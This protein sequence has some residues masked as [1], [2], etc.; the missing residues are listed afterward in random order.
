M[1]KPEEGL[2]VARVTE[3]GERRMHADENAV[4]DNQMRQLF[5]DRAKA[6]EDAQEDARKQRQE[7]AQRQAEA[8]AARDHA[9]KLAALQAQK[10]KRCHNCMIK[11]VAGLIIA[12]G[13][14]VATHCYGMYV[15]VAVVTGCCVAAVCRVAWYVAA[16]NK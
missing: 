14:A 2:Y 13:M 12:A 16:R 4:C 11:D 7:D 5:E 8:D 10:R 3:D 9:T 1:N 15:L 6:R